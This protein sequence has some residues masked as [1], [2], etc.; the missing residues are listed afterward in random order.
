M[1]SPE[2]PL[3]VTSPGALT[4]VSHEAGKLLAKRGL[5]L[6]RH[7]HAFAV[8]SQTTLIVDSPIL[9]L[10]RLVS[11]GEADEA[12]ELAEEI[13]HGSDVAAATEAL[14]IIL[15]IAASD[16]G[17]YAGFVAVRY[18]IGT[19]PYGRDYDASA[20]WALLSA[21]KGCALGEGYL[22]WLYSIGRGVPQDFIAA[23]HYAQSAINK[24]CSRPLGL[25]ALAYWRGTGTAPDHPRAHAYLTAMLS[26]R[27][28]F[29]TQEEKQALREIERTLDP[30]ALQM[31][32][33]IQLEFH[34]A[35]RRHFPWQLP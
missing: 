13:G 6:L 14:G 5:S 25:A 33:M 1:T 8:F 12:F 20:K 11:C 9:R 22:A 15:R 28:K 21:N 18:N 7:H 35:C 4:S 3:I 34:D 17:F 30:V 27:D 16:D 23:I 26:L 32:E 31:S 10:R 2:L 29:Q 24:G 19:P